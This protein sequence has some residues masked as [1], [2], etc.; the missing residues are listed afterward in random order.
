MKNKI[1]LSL[2]GLQ[3]GFLQKQAELQKQALEPWKGALIGGGIGGLG[4]GGLG[5]L[6]GDSWKSTLGGALAGGA[7]GAGLGYG[8]AARKHLKELEKIKPEYEKI[9]PESDMF[10]RLRRL[11]QENRKNI[12]L[13]ELGEITVEEFKR[14]RQELDRQIAKLVKKLNLEMD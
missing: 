11:V 6:L 8:L 5:Y 9:K 10:N 12:K 2:A 3:Q 7:G 1:Q 13:R 14:K 4:G